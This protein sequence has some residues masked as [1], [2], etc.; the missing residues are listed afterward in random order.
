[1][2]FRSW[3]EESQGVPVAGNPNVI[4]NKTVRFS[5]E[6]ARTLRDL[7]SKT[8]MGQG[9]RN[10]FIVVFDS[11]TREAQNAL[12][13]SIEEPT[14]DT[15]FLFITATDE[16]LLPTIRSR[17]Q[18]LRDTQSGEETNFLSLPFTERE[19]LC[20]GLCGDSKKDIPPKRRELAE[21]VDGVLH[22]I[23]VHKDK[24][25]EWKRHYRE[26]EKL[27]TY[28]MDRSSSVKYIGEYMSVTLSV[29]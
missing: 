11:I 9:N 14:G 13:K 10:I 28:V 22:E 3:L 8:S 19:K 1:M 24:M 17:V 18:I 23:V 6:M 5:I 20:A 16:T 27:R 4:I 2:L 7:Q 29:I 26:L 21:L 15:L 25:P 12:L